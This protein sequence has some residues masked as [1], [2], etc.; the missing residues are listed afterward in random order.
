MDEGTLHMAKAMVNM[1][2][3]EEDMS[4]ASAAAVMV[5][6]TKTDKTAV[7]KIKM[8]EKLQGFRYV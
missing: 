6:E 1:S 8:Q 2:I 3:H 5:A 4:Y 7:G